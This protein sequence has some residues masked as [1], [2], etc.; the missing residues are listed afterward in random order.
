MFYKPTF[1]V[2]SEWDNTQILLGSALCNHPIP[3]LKLKYIYLVI[4]NRMSVQVLALTC[5]CS[6][7]CV[8]QCASQ[9]TCTNEEETAVIWFLSSEGMLDGVNA[10]SH[11]SVYGW[12]EKSKIGRISVRNEDVK[13]TS[14]STDDLKILQ[15]L[16]IVTVN[17]FTFTI[18]IAFWLYLLYNTRGV[19]MLA[20]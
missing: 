15:G 7:A 14:T 19:D 4:Y 13:H 1:H 11:W 17:L 16:E 2:T 20:R 5:L 18:F 3:L 10:Q 9:A 6:D 8:F 12:I